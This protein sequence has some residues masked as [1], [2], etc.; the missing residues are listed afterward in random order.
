MILNGITLEQVDSIY[1]RMG[2][3]EL[4]VLPWHE[5][6]LV[7]PKIGALTPVLVGLITGAI[8]QIPEFP[9]LSGFLE[10]FVVLPEAV[11]RTAVK[12]GMSEE[13]ERLLRARGD[14]ARILLCIDQAHPKFTRLHMWADV[15]G[16]TKYA[17]KDGRDWYIKQ[18]T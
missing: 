11:D 6:Q 3:K 12:M 4:F 2:V 14:V 16:Y 7:N 17:E 13:A 9:G 10:H 15:C 18:L 8:E 5:W 1:Q